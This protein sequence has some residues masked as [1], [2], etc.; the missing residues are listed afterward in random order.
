[1]CNS[2]SPVHHPHEGCNEDESFSGGHASFV[3][4]DTIK[5]HR[6]FC[7]VE[8]TVYEVSLEEIKIHVDSTLSICACCTGVHLRRIKKQ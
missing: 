2:Y 4:L 7:E 1:M 5:P 6:W 8:W 3:S